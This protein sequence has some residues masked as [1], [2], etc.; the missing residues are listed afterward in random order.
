MLY[1]KRKRNKNEIDRFKKNENEIRTK[2]I[3]GKPDK[4]G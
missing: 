4:N 3:D 1:Q 2:M